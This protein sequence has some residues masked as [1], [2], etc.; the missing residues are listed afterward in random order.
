MESREV[1]RRVRAGFDFPG[2]DSQVPAISNW[3]KESSNPSLA[4]WGTFVCELGTECYGTD[5]QVKVGEP[6]P[7]LTIRAD[8]ASQG[9]PSGLAERS[10]GVGNQEGPPSP[11]LSSS[12]PS[13]S[14]PFF[15]YLAHVPFVH[16][17]HSPQVE[18]VACVAPGSNS[19]HQ[20]WQ[21]AKLLGKPLCWPSFTSELGMLMTSNKELGGPCCSE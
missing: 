3:L 12:L 11:L 18:L 7:L 16:S 8:R 21:Q 1:W 9:K 4:S 20:A 10:C 2:L 13:P 5:V 15:P 19:G 17:N 14:R 6:S